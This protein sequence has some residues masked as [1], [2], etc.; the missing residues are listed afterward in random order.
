M[1]AFQC[2]LSVALLLNLSCNSLILIYCNYC[3]FVLFCCFI[4]PLIN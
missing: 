2:K 4:E 1:L 3:L